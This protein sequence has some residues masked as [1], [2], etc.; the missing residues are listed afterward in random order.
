ME[1][2]QISEIHG[3]EID[4][5][6]FASLLPLMLHCGLLLVKMLQCALQKLQ[7]LRRP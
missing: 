7:E 1:I 3:R 2:S 6:D 4:G 5:Q